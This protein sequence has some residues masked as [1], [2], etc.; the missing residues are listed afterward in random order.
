MSAAAQAKLKPNTI[1]RKVHDG[2][3]VG[4]QLD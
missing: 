3:T 4:H 1:R 2:G